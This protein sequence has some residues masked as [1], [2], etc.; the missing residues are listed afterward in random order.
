MAVVEQRDSDPQLQGGHEDEGNE[1]GAVYPAALRGSRRAGRSRHH[2]GSRAAMHR[3]GHWCAGRLV[4][5]R[6]GGLPTSL[7]KIATKA[8][9]I[10]R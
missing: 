5:V 6:V 9:K 7:R 3:A 10:T 4:C 1:K 8:R 2:A